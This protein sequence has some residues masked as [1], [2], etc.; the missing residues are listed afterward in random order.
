MEQVVHV[1]LSVVMTQVAVKPLADYGTQK[2]TS[3]SHVVTVMACVCFFVCLSLCTFNLFKAC[4]NQFL[5]LTDR[6]SVIGENK[7]IGNDIHVHLEG[8]VVESQTT[9]IKSVFRSLIL[10]F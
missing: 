5:D 4:I 10:H 7:H 8:H 6:K 3:V 2:Y 9:G 1:E